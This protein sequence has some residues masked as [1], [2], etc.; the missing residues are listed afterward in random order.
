MVTKG[1]KQ[2]SGIDYFEVFNP[3]TRLDAIHM[4]ISLSA[5]NK[6]K[7]HQIDVKFVFLNGTLKEVYVGQPI[8]Y[9]IEDKE[10]KVY[11]LKNYM[12]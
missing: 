9:E 11:I 8:E 4:L 5:Q 10:D 2:K 6:L 12:A 3:T 1:Y 7:I